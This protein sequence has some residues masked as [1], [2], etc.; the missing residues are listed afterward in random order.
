[1]L[2][3][4]KTLIKYDSELYKFDRIE[5]KL[6][7]RSD[8]HALLLIDSLMPGTSNIIGSATHDCIYLAINV[9]VLAKVAKEEHIRDLVRC[10]IFF[11]DNLLCM[12]V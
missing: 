6:S 2:D 9:K 1:M 11:E 4:Q 10:G 12:H 3:L 5:N 8:L 7:N